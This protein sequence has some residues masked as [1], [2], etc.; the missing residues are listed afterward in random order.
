MKKVIVIILVILSCF[1][2]GYIASLFQVNAIE[3]WYPTLNKSSLTPPNWVFP[4]VWNI[5]Y[6]FMGLSIACIVC[7]KNPKEV[8]LMKIFTVQILLN[9][10]WSISFFYLQSPLLGLINIILLIVAILFYLVQTYRWANKF[11]FSLFIPYLLWVLFAGY[12]NLYI[13]LYN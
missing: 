11:S 7:R 10:L 3:T 8:Y 5:L 9:F 12:L 1:A 13:V 4:I 2:V 6:L